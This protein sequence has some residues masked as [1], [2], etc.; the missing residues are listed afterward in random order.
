MLTAMVVASQAG[1]SAPRAKW[2]KGMQEIL[3]AVPLLH[4]E[5]CIHPGCPEDPARLSSGT[6]TTLG[7]LCFYWHSIGRCRTQSLDRAYAAYLSCGVARAC[8]AAGAASISVGEC[9]LRIHDDGQVCGV[10]RLLAATHGNVAASFLQCWEEL[11]RSGVLVH[12]YHGE[13][14]SL[15]D[16]LL[17]G[18]LY[19]RC[20]RRR[21]LPVGERAARLTAALHDSCLPWVA[22]GMQLYAKN[23]AWPSYAS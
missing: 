10:G 12:A 15:A 8:S 16:L 4:G 19:E 7:L 17:C 6:C 18:A 5:V 21:R 9:Q 23:L 13:K 11:R 22:C 3:A 20:K 1:E 2:A 14:D